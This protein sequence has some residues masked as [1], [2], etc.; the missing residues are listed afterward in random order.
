M[1]RTKPVRESASWGKNG[2]RVGFMDKAERAETL[3]I[4]VFFRENLGCWK[5]LVE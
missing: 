1:A 4:S 3:G 5:M 2:E